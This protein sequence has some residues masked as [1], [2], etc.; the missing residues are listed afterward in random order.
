[1]DLAGEGFQQLCND[2]QQVEAGEPLVKF[3]LEKIKAAGKE[4]HSA[5]VVTNKEV[6]LDCTGLK[7]GRVSKGKDTV[8]TA[9]TN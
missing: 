8:F 7:E 2:G 4:L 5:L 3:D 6:V 9:Q 1:V